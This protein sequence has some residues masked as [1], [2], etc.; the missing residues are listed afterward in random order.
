M[1]DHNPAVGGHLQIQLDAVAV[2]DGGAEGGEGIFTAGAV[3]KKP[4]M[5]EVAVVKFYLERCFFSEG[6]ALRAQAPT[7]SNPRETS[8][9]N[10]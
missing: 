6:M 1:K 9:F 4:A 8:C 2:L 10:I 7:P 3:I 5:G